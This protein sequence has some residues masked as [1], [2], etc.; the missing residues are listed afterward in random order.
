MPGGKANADS[1]LLLG[2]PRPQPAPSA[3][4]PPARPAPP[5]PARKGKDEKGQSRRAASEV[6]GTKCKDLQR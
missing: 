1:A 5:R 2:P 3:D 6:E 4:R